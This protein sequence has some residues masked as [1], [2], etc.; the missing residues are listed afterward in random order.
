MAEAWSAFIQLS[1]PTRQLLREA[2]LNYNY[3]LICRLE[4]AFIDRLMSVPVRSEELALSCQFVC[5]R[6][7]GGGG[8]LL[9]KTRRRAT[10]CIRIGQAWRLVGFAASCPLLACP[11]L[12]NQSSATTTWLFSSKTLE[13]RL[14][15]QSSILGVFFSSHFTSPHQADRRICHGVSKYYSLLSWSETTSRGQRVT[16]VM[17]P[18]VD[19]SFLFVAPYTPS[20]AM[21]DRRSEFNAGRCPQ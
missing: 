16:I 2:L 11:P 10:A 12:Y 8:V 19:R 7:G 20:F 3:E 15:A 17:K 4:A 14:P 5:L 9:N 6:G 13:V 21:A 18:K 1:L